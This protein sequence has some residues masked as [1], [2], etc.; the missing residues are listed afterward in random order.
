MADIYTHTEDGQTRQLDWGIWRRWVVANAVGEAI[1]LGCT[2]L[3][4]IFLAATATNVLGPI[5]FAALAVLG[6]T[7]IE[8]LIVGTTQWLVLQDPL[9]KLS[10]R[11]WALAT[12][13]GAC[14]AW[15]L[16]V[17]PGTMMPVDAGASPASMSGLAIDGLAFVMGLV[18]GP[19]LSVPQWLVLRLYLHRTG[20]WMLANALAWA[21]GMV[22]IF[23]GTNLI[24]PVG[25]TPAIAVLLVV[26]LVSAGA[27]VGAIHGLVLI[28]LLRREQMLTR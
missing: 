6:G 19:I 4:T 14:I 22:V 7:V 11:R 16:G 28:W 17:L 1:G 25:I 27:V 23:L 10:W 12:A 20:W 8:G 18:L 9:P 26:Y 2:L 13:V 24:P 21:C 15:A 3:L 5:G